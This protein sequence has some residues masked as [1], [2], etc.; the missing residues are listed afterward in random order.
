[1]G[2]LLANAADESVGANASA[3]VETSLR[4]A[5]KKLKFTL[6]PRLPVEHP[7]TRQ[8]LD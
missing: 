6:T 5:H 7:A 2:F 4:E 8:M 1:V 3:A